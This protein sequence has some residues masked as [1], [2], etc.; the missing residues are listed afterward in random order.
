MTNEERGEKAWLLHNTIQTNELLRRKLLFDNMQ[1][2]NELHAHK[3]YQV[4]LGDQS[5]PWRAYLGQH[6]VFYT[7]S[8]VYTLEKIYQKFVKEL[9]VNTEILARIPTTKLSNLIAIV[10]NDNVHEWL[11]K[12]ETLTTQ[13]F[14]DE[15]RK[16]QGKISYLDCSHTDSKRYEICST[17]GFRHAM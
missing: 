8:K 3:L 12:A 5:A 10:N 17:C 11:T 14:A 9:N 6:E 7:A 1:A 13:D 4:V 15:L 2:L 16:T